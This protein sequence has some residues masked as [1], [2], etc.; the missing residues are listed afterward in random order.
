MLVLEVTDLK[1]RGQ[2]D[3]WGRLEAAMASE[4]T[5]I[6]VRGNMHMDNRVIED[7]EFKS[8]LK[9]DLWGCLEAAMASEAA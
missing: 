1:S 2:I 8:E 4:V 5:K 6:P 7:A 3:L 9:F